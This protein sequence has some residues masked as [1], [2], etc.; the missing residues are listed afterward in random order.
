MWRQ[1]SCVNNPLRRD[2]L[3]ETLTWT[4]NPV[5]APKQFASVTSRRVHHGHGPWPQQPLCRQPLPGVTNSWWWIVLSANMWRQLSCVNN[6]MRRDRTAF[7][8]AHMNKKKPGVCTKTVRI[9]NLKAWSPWS[10]AMATATTQNEHRDTGFDLEDGYGFME[11]S[12]GVAEW[13]REYDRSRHPISEVTERKVN[14]NRENCWTQVSMREV[15]SWFMMNAARSIDS[16]LC[17]SHLQVFASGWCL[18]FSI[19]RTLLNCGEVHFFLQGNDGQLC[20]YIC[21]GGSFCNGL[22]VCKLHSKV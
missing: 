4:E 21:R 13:S 15:V 1:K 2:L 8:N 7:R 18:Q 20:Q 10:W 19:W 3:S 12:C 5:F 11:F 16:S 14:Y 17:T 6:P 9:R 22:N